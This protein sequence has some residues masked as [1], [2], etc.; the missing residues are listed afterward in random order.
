[1]GW[2]DQNYVARRL[3]AHYGLGATTYRARFADRAAL[4]PGPAAP[5]DG[6]ARSAG[7]SPSRMTQAA[8][9][10][11]GQLCTGSLLCMCPM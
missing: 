4:H 11:T 10:G 5:P 6:P 8:G 7:R 2:P 3:K 1:M 9:Q